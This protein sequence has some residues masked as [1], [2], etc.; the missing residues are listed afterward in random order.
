MAP[1]DDDL[2]EGMSRSKRRG[3]Y[4]EMHAEITDTNRKKENQDAQVRL[5]AFLPT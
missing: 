5:P 3:S 1:S 2:P 4:I